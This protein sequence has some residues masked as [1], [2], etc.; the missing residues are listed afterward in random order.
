MLGACA[1]RPHAAPGADACSAKDKS[2]Y[3]AASMQEI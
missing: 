1:P 2:K 3:D